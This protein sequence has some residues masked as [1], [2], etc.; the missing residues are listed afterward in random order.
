MIAPKTSRWQLALELTLYCLT[1][2]K[3]LHQESKADSTS[4]SR[5]M[6]AVANQVHSTAQQICARIGWNP[7]DAATQP[8]TGTRE[9]VLNLSDPRTDHCN[10]GF[11]N[12]CLSGAPPSFSRR[13][14][15]VVDDGGH[16]V[17]SRHARRRMAHSEVRQSEHRDWVDIG[18]WPRAALI[19]E[20]NTV[21]TLSVALL[22]YG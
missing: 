21:L 14:G 19:A 17:H 16:R 22:C 2:S 20:S 4:L 13:F 1:R 9:R 11:E 5:V 3:R 12:S 10:L 18:V 8:P 15:Q 7:I 6:A